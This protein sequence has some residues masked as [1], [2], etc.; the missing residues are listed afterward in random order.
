[1][2]GRFELEAVRIWSSATETVM[3][4]LTGFLSTFKKFCLRLVNNI[5]KLYTN[6]HFERLVPP[7]GMEPK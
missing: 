5:M 1:M 7:V 3:C 2:V 6:A 4:G